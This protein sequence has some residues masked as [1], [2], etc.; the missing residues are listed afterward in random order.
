MVVTAIEAAGRRKL[1]VYLDGESAFPVFASELSSW[2]LSIQEGQML[3]HDQEAVLLKK[4]GKLAC[5]AAMDALVRRDYSRLQL[6][7]LLEKKGFMPLLVSLAIDYV[8]SFGYLD[9]ERFTRNAVQARR[10]MISRR[11]LEYKLKQQG[12]E[13]WIV[14]RA[15]EESGWDDQEGISRELS[16]RFPDD[17]LPERGS[18]EYQRLCQSLIRKGYSYAD[19]LRSMLSKER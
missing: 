7:R 4:A 5:A 2:D 6:I 16:K 3:D 11:M 13:E 1:R 12:I 14:Q 17:S 8:S 18:R 15:I 10:G 9:D 19:I